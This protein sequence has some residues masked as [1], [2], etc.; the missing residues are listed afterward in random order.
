MRLVFKLHDFCFFEG[1]AGA[2]SGF[3]LYP[4]E[5]KEVV[6]IVIHDIDLCFNGCMLTW[7]MQQFNDVQQCPHHVHRYL[8]GQWLCFWL[9]CQ[10]EREYACSPLDEG[11]LARLATYIPAHRANLFG[12]VSAKLFLRGPSGQGVFRM[13]KLF[14]CMRGQFFISQSAL[15]D[16]CVLAFANLAQSGEAVTDEQGAPHDCSSALGPRNFCKEVTQMEELAKALEQWRELWRLALR[17]FRVGCIL[18]VCPGLLESFR[19]DGM[20]RYT[21]G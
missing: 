16:A 7:T 4:E 21:W 12:L 14:I 9:Q 20:I 15:A 17:A 11:Q 8:D 18:K 13:S 19:G 3:P 6:K 5:Y 2:L 10:K 1:C